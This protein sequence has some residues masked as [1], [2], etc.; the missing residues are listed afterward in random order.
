MSLF[1]SAFDG[2]ILTSKC[3]QEKYTQVEYSEKIDTSTK[4]MIFQNHTFHKSNK[5]H[6]FKALLRNIPSTIYVKRKV[7]VLC[8]LM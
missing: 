2:D 3:K 8:K 4:I 6:K 1:L 7:I 5:H